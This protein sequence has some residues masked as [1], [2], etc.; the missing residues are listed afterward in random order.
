MIEVMVVVRLVGD[1]WR[2]VSGVGCDGWRLAP[3]INWDSLW[4]EFVGGLTL[5][6]ELSHAGRVPPS[7]QMVI[8][9]CC[10]T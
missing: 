3:L 7:P 5:Q 4:C 6:N 1:L 10:S 2:V 9:R 8:M